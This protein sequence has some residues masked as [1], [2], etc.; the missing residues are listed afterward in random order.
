MPKK[1]KTMDKT[2]RNEETS[3][4]LEEIQ[5]FNFSLFGKNKIEFHNG[6]NFLNYSSDID[7]IVFNYILTCSL[8]PQFMMKHKFM[9]HI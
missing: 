8:N 1:T 7:K 2:I 3:C 5:F 4:L 9:D 6:I